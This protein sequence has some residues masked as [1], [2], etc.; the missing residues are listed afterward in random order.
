MKPGYFYCEAY[1]C[2]MPV[3]TC[4]AR[5]VNVQKGREILCGGYHPGAFDTGCR[6]C[7][8]GRGL[9]MRK[10]EA[11]EFLETGGGEGKVCDHPECPFKGGEQPLGL[12]SPGTFAG[13]RDHW[14][15]TCR[16]R[17]NKALKARRAESDAKKS[18]EEIGS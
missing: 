13:G 6:D 3:A 11:V 12:F 7:E 17:H 9:E 1:R 10:N 14:C 18:R 5:R 2:T 15:R 4:V 8:Q 16:N